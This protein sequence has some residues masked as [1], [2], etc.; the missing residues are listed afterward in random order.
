M[1]CKINIFTGFGSIGACIEGPI[2][3]LFS[4]YYGWGGVFYLM[5]GLTTFGALA[6]FRA[7]MLH[8]KLRQS[9]HLTEVR[10]V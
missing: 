6:V 3:G 5:T 2:I 4:M 10:F 7:S 1:L 9:S 8:T